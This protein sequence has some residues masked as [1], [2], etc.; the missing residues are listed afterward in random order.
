MIRSMRWA[1]RGSVVNIRGGL[2]KEF[3][4]DGHL[5]AAPCGCKLSKARGVGETGATMQW[6]DLRR[7]RP[8]PVDRRRPEARG[9]LSAG[10]C[11]R[12]DACYNA[13]ERGRFH[14]AVCREPT[15]RRD[16]DEALRGWPYEPD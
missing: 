15:M 10:G 6:R 11:R 9:I 7:P 2:V 13:K 16:I 1:R 14:G 4:G 3:S 5:R 12:A 8:P